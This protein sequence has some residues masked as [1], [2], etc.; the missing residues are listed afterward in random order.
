MFG[1][2]AIKWAF[3]YGIIGL[4]QGY[5]VH[6]NICDTLTPNL[7]MFNYSTLTWPFK[8]THSNS[9]TKH[10]GNVETKVINGVKTTNP[11]GSTW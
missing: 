3:V 8:H 1:L 2:H 9:N 11:Q 5:G 7:I 6:F 4:Q 10:N